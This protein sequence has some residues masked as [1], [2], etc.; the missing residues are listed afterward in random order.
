L[1]ELLPFEP[2][3]LTGRPRRHR[4]LNR[5]ILLR[6]RGPVL[7]VR[8]ARGVLFFFLSG[9]LSGCGQ[10]DK[11]A[12]QRRNQRRPAV[13]DQR[14]APAPGTYTVPATTG[15]K[16]GSPRGG[17]SAAACVNP[18]RGAAPRSRYSRCRIAGP[19]SAY[20]APHLRLDAPSE[21]SALAPGGPPGLQALVDGARFLRAAISPAAK[22][23]K[24]KSAAVG[25]PG[26]C[27]R[28]RRPACHAV[29]V[30]GPDRCSALRAPTVGYPPPAA[31]VGVVE[32]TRT[33]A[34]PAP[35]AGG[36]PAGGGCGP[37]LSFRVVEF[38]RSPARNRLVAFAR[39]TGLGAR[40]A[41][42]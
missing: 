22:K 9:A 33:G 38:S 11:V 31:S 35:A 6:R 23:K 37:A 30:H 28:A 20:G 10:S 16:S 27:P 3:C 13:E 1:A 8:G 34:P 24:Q 41:A 26:S 15:V 40:C 18:K 4:F 12:A 5:T 39:R 29:N 19:R 36:V 2:C 21:Y 42:C 14:R 25:P 17:S 7:G 32:R